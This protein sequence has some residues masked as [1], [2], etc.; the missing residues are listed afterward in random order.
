MLCCLFKTNEI[1]YGT[2]L[3]N[4]LSKK[5]KNKN[6]YDSSLI[7]QYG[8]DIDFKKI[9]FPKILENI[10]FEIG[11]NPDD[12]KSQR[13]LFSGNYLNVYLNY[14]PKKYCRNNFNLLLNELIRETEFNIEYIRSDAL[15]QY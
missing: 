9:I 7:K 10:K 15:L 11:Y 8:K 2:K 13:I 1:I 4:L 6:V 14:I 5:L 3:I 12:I